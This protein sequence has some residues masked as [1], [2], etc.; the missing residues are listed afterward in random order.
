MNSS[1]VPSGESHYSEDH[2]SMATSQGVTPYCIAAYD[3]PPQ[4]EEDLGFSAGDHIELV[5][6]ISAD[7]LKG[8]LGEKIGMFPASFVDV[9][10]DID[11]SG[12]SPTSRAIFSL[13]SL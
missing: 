8:K 9:K 12:K 11:T 5:E 1:A 2:I 13:F 10:V 3:Y 4:T 7:W 6:R